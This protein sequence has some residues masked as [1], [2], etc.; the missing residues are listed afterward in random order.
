[1]AGHN[2]ATRHEVLAALEELLAPATAEA[3]Q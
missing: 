2:C 1:M 3:A